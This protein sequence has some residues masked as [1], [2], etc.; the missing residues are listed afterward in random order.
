MTKVSQSGDRMTK[1]IVD[2]AKVL[3]PE[4][5]ITTRPKDADLLA[6]LHLLAARYR[7]PLRDAR[8]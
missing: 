1:T 8:G 3:R 6:T 5:G 2:L 7:I 4:P